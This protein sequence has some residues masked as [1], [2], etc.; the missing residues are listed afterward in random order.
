MFA[1]HDLLSTIYSVIRYKYAI[2]CLKWD[3]EGGFTWAPYIIE[4]KDEVLLVNSSGLLSRFSDLSL[5]S[6]ATALSNK[7]GQKAQEI[8]SAMNPKNIESKHKTKVLCVLFSQMSRI[9]DSVSNMYWEHRMNT[10]ENVG[11]TEY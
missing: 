11:K 5:E 3:P 8:Q 2:K 7:K 6:L 4:K 1:L 10:V 9:Y